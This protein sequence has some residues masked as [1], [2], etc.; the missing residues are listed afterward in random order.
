MFQRRVELWGEG[1]RFL[2]LKRLNLPLD[3]GPAPRDGYN[4]NWWQAIAGA[5]STSFVLTNWDP[6][7]SNFNMYGDGTVIGNAN[8]YR[9]AGHKEWQFLFHQ[10]VIDSNPLCEQNPL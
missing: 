10:D 9:E 8:R 4:K 7:A 1:F 2:D 3:R 5:G 6:E